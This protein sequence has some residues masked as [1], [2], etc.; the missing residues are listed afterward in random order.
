[1]FHRLGRGGGE[2]QGYL[3]DLWLAEALAAVLARP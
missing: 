3:D 1:V 2:S